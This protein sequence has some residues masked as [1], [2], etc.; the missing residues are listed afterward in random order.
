MEYT[1]GDFDLRAKITNEKEVTIDYIVKEAEQIYAIVKKHKLKTLDDADAM[2]SDLQ[3]THPDFSKA[4]PIVLRYMCQMQ[5]YDSRALRSYLTKIQRHPYKTEDEYLES[6]A[7]YV[8]MLYKSRNKHWNATNVANLRN[9]IRGI[10][11]QEHETFKNY[12]AA[13]DKEVNAETQHLNDLAMDDL[14]QFVRKIGV[15][16]MASAGTIRVESD[17]QG[18]APVL[19]DAL[20][21]DTVSQF[22]NS[23]DALLL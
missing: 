20:I 15:D 9:N 8:V 7:D 23:A 14:R 13:F 12:V 2:L 5:E 16:G 22:V 3:K 4:Y 17:I 18:D 6:Q 19:L 10:L 11:K 1:T 21:P